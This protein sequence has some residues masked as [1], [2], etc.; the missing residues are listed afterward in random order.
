MN[1][2][3]DGSFSCWC[4]HFHL[5]PHVQHLVSR[6]LRGPVKAK[7]GWSVTRPIPFQLSNRCKHI[8]IHTQTQPPPLYGKH[9]HTRHTVVYLVCGPLYLHRHN[10][11]CITN[12]LE[13]EHRG[14]WLACSFTW[15]ALCTFTWHYITTEH[16]EPDSTALCHKSQYIV[17]TNRI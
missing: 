8:N 12:R 9:T 16:L 10:E 3:R 6:G 17:Y 14:R 13:G 2:E 15:A 1:W 4:I 5:R 7:P 11:V